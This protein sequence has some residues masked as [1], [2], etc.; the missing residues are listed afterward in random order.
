[1]TTQVKRGTVEDHELAVLCAIAIRQRP[2]GW[3]PVGGEAMVSLTEADFFNPTHRL[4]FRALKGIH[5]GSE[6]MIREQLPI[7]LDALGVQYFDIQSLFQPRH[8]PTQVRDLIRVVKQWAAEIR[9][10]SLCVAV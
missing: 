1:M 7:R 10:G 9:A 2:E 3:S 5:S 8:G 4:V 6:I